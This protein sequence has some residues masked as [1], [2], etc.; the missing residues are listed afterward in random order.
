MPKLLA[1]YLD[2]HEA[3]NKTAEALTKHG[4]TFIAAQHLHK[5]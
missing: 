2:K 4:L 3:L 5:N 1:N